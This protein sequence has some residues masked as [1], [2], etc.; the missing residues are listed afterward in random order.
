MSTEARV[1]HRTASPGITTPVDRRYRRPDG[2]PA[3]R[4]RRSRSW[5]ARLRAAALV[6]LVMAGAGWGVNRVLASDLF[7]VQTVT[8]RGNRHLSAEEIEALVIG[9]RG[10]RVFAVD[11]ETYRRRVLASP[12]VEQVSLARVLPATIVIDVVERTPMALARLDQVLY[13]VDSTGNIIDEYHAEYREF[14]LPLVDGLLEAAA[15]APAAGDPE[16]AALL[17]ALFADL[18]ARPALRSRLSQVDVS[19]PRDVAVLLDDDPAWLHLGKERFEE[20]LQRYLDLRPA[21]Q[22]RFGAMDYVDLRFDERVYVR[23][24][25]RRAARR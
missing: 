4:R 25:E 12:W 3:R 23:G 7:V 15:D 5:G 13:L 17:T 19:N 10:E 9:L 21:L 22:D 18:E 8:I 11:F 14:D 6:L 20:R 2:V 24:R 16:R 1:P